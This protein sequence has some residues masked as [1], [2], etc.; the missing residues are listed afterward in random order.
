MRRRSFFYAGDFMIRVFALSLA[1]LLA[2]PALAVELEGVKVQATAHVSGQALVLNGAGVRTKLV[3][4]VYVASLYLP[5]RAHDLASVLAKGPRRVQLNMLRT[6]GADQLV[7]AIDEGLKDNNTADELAATK[8][9]RA[10]MTAIVN[11]FGELK[12]GSVVQIDYAEGTTTISLNGVAKGTIP[13]DAFNIAL[14]RVWLGDHPVQSD[15]KK[16]MLGG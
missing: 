12:E 16:S 8:A 9:G 7:E 2:V 6:L 1:C 11:G 13:S 4:K 3:F 14:M 5:A 15:L 10:Q